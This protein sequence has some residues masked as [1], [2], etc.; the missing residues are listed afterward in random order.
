MQRERRFWLLIVLALAVGGCES[1]EDQARIPTDALPEA[2]FAM[3]PEDL[4]ADGL[5]RHPMPA[6]AEA[7]KAA[8]ERHH[9]RQLRGGA[10]VTVDVTVDADGQVQSVR[11][12]PRSTNPQVRRVLRDKDGS[13]RMVKPG[14]GDPAAAAAAEAA[15]REVRFTPAIRDGQAV[16]HTF[17]MTVT[18]PS[19]TREAP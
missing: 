9:P 18:F 12:R 16:P 3:N 13:E 17:R 6:S 11:P 1:R 10:S 5:D 2:A 8:M 7:F 14:P 15:L 19:D 4:R